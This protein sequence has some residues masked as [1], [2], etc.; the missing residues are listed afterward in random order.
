MKYRYVSFYSHDPAQLP[1]SYETS[2]SIARHI[3]ITQD[4]LRKR[5]A[6]NDNIIRHGSLSFER[7]KK[8]VIK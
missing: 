6:K 5:F 2:K 7:F 3:G 1:L 8:E 4:A